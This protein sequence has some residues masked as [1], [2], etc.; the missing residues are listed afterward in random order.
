MYTYLIWQRKQPI[1]FSNLLMLTERVRPG[2]NSIDI[3]PLLNWNT[4]NMPVKQTIRH[5]PN[6]RSKMG[7]KRFPL[8]Q[9]ICVFIWLEFIGI[10]DIIILN[11]VN[12]RYIV[13]QTPHHKHGVKC[14]NI[15][16]L[17]VYIFK[18][19]HNHGF[20]VIF[21]A[22]F[23]NTYRTDVDCWRSETWIK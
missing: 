21:I 9:C 5:N 10:C 3:K 20:S 16:T 14:D 19:M 15:K 23:Q 18:N 13:H 17:F 2:T 11:I 8:L 6:L 7:P 22:I 4:S 1:S 12:R